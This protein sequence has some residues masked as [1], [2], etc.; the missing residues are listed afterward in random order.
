MLPKFTTSI[1]VSVL[2]K[3]QMNLLD[4]NMLCSVVGY[5]WL[6]TMWFDTCSV[7]CCDKGAIARNDCCIS[8]NCCLHWIT[9]QS[10]CSQVG[11]VHYW[12]L[13]LPCGRRCSITWPITYCEV[14]CKVVI[15]QLDCGSACCNL[16][17]NSKC[18]CK[19]RI[20]FAQCSVCSAWHCKEFSSW[21]IV[22]QVQ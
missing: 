6:G 21:C 10:I 18:G 14:G 12:W 11:K 16:S 5:L 1:K 22:F 17:H 9:V 13:K 2:I 15:L 8:S 3:S 19:H 7:C 4:N 20:T